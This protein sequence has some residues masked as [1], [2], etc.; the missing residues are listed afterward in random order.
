MDTNEKTGRIPS[1][2]DTELGYLE[3]MLAAFSLLMCLVTIFY[4]IPNWID[5]YSMGWPTPRT[6]PYTTCAIHAFLCTIW[7][8]NSLFGRDVKALSGEVIKQGITLNAI[9]IILCFV[10]YYVGYLVGGV[11]A[12]A[13]IITLI[14]GPRYWKQAAVGSVV[15]SLLY[16]FFFIYV[17][18]IGLP[19]G[20]LI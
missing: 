9:V 2:R 14:K 4:L 6:F 3:V 5:E 15:I 17:M 1:F 12:V 18:K 19:K 13:S 8:V 20:M 11:L 7:L 10:I 16:Y